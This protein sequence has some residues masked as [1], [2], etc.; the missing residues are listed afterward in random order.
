MEPWQAMP[1]CQEGSKTTERKKKGKVMH[2]HR[3][4]A[5]HTPTTISVWS[6]WLQLLCVYVC[7]CV[8][9]F[10]L[11]LFFSLFHP[12]SHAHALTST[13]T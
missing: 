9:T 11:P 10:L 5:S 2:C 12:G 3:K 1:K 8:G 6:F 13:Q 4:L 7:M